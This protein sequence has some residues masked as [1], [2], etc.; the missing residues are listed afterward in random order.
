[1]TTAFHPR[2]PKDLHPPNILIMTASPSATPLPS[3][4]TLLSSVCDEEKREAVRLY[5][6]GY[7]WDY[8]MRQHEIAVPME[9]LFGRAVCALVHDPDTDARGDIEVREY[10]GRY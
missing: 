3:I 2:F 7:L 5:R 1:M 9:P 4:C 8:V 6:E 10:S